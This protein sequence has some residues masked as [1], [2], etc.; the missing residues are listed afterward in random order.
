MKLERFGKLS[1]DD[2][3]QGLLVSIAGDIR[4]KHHLRK[5]QRQN[6]VVM[7]QAHEDMRRKHDKFDEQIKSYHLFIDSS[8]ASLQKGS[9]RI[10]NVGRKDA[11]L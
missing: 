1:R 11:E 5:M 4:Q 8:M 6:A 3:F 10:A 7:E 9:V 2:N